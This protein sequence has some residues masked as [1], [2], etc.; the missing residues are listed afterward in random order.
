MYNKKIIIKLLPV[1]AMATNSLYYNSI[2]I[3]TF[4]ISGLSK[5]IGKHLDVFDDLP[6]WFMLFVILI[7]V[8]LLTEVTMNAA[9][10]SL[11]MP[12]VAPLVSIHISEEHK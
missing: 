9:T 6:R 2:H 1:F 11:L 3:V 12:I 7:L 8:A 4:Q 10:C 5:W